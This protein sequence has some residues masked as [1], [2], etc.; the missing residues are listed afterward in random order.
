MSEQSKRDSYPF[1]V[2][3]GAACIGTVLGGAVVWIGV[4]ARGGGDQAEVLAAPSTA[5]E[6]GDE[7]SPN[8]GGSNS[9]QTPA[10]TPDVESAAP[11]PTL[12]SNTDPGESP[13][14]RA[15]AATRDSVVSVEIGGRVSGAGVVYDATGL[16]LTNYHVI[17]SVLQAQ[18]NFG[19][20]RVSPA[21]A[22]FPDGRVRAARVIAADPD[23]DIAILK[24]ER[25]QMGN[26]DE[27]FTAAPI[28][29]SAALRLGEQVF[30]IGSPVGFEATVATG[31]VSALDRTEILAKRQLAL[32]QIDASINFG[33]SG[34]PLFSLRGELVGINTARSSRGEGIGFAIPIDRIRLFLRA[35]EDGTRGRA[36]IVGVS[37]SAEA[38][39]EAEISGLGYH[40]GVRVETV[41]VGKSAALSGLREGDVIV[42]IRGRRHDE[43]R[44]DLRGRTELGRIFGE[45]IRAL[46]PGETIAVTVVRTPEQ[47]RPA[48]AVELDLAVEA[49][50]ISEQASI[51]MEELLG[52]YLDPNSTVPQVEGIVPGSPVSRLRGASVLE[53]A[54]IISIFQSPVG[55]IETLASRLAL[56]RRAAAGGGRRSIAVTFETRDGQ[57]IETSTYPLVRAR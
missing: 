40:S 25:E 19:Q 11:D 15:I 2:A 52:L 35:L 50:S 57:R 54:K 53:G 18:A 36:G 55:D 45:T 39:V 48:I 16:V 47:G 14:V 30:A 56:L 4:G 23:E 13:L 51:D 7:P 32:I 49:A 10:G 33:N 20:Q 22:R 9:G 27:R 24:L 3:M 8:S 1:W 46:L 5:L 21:A 6:K 31:I 17:E 26:E 29:S 43:L 28:G 42:A 37:L 34:G 44:A 38:E 12:D 41:E